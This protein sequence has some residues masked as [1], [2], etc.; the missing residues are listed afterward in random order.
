M[1]IAPEEP[2]VSQARPN[3]RVALD[4]ANRAPR[5][6]ARTRRGTPCQKPAVH[7]RPRCQLHGCAKGAG[8]QEGERNG[9]FV[10]GKRSKAAAEE[11]REMRRALVIL[12]ALTGR[13]PRRR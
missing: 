12:D 13:V 5:C 11:A 1:S 9:R 6:G 7:G 3:W 8:G 2:E 4:A 10:H